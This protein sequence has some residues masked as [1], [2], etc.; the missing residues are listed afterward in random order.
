MQSRIET[1]NN[2]ASGLPTVWSVGDAD[3]PDFLEAFDL[4][5]AT[6]N[7]IRFADAAHAAG[8]SDCAERSPDLILFAASRSGML[9]GRDVERLRRRV[10]LAGLVALLGS[11]CEGETRTGRPAPGVL[12]CFWYD[13]P[14]WWRRQL[15]LRVAGLC[16]DW[17]RPATKDAYDPGTNL[18]H[19]RNSSGGLIVLETTCWET[20]DALGDVLRA[21]GYATVW[22]RPGGCGAQVCG[23]TAGIW[24]G[25]QLDE[26]EVSRL[27]E[28]CRRLAKD[29][30]PVIALADFPRRER[31]EV[32]YRAGAAAVLGKPWLNADLLAT[33]ERLRQRS[34][35]SDTD[36]KIARAA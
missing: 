34:V 19:V 33:L 7:V 15:A 6:A 35:R 1:I 28:F 17:A 24:E 20:G 5:H 11:W 13:F 22:I 18:Q 29:D 21:S 3:D 23:A 8:D 31:C 27:S 32:A 2:A 36:S 10:P 25:R 4:L 9:R 30:A 14:H 12:R 26:P 16:P